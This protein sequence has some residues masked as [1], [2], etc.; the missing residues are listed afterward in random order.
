MTEYGFENV[1]INEVLTNILKDQAKTLIFQ[2]MVKLINIYMEYKFQAI[3][4]DRG[5]K[6][7]AQTGD[8]KMDIKE[9][10]LKKTLY[11]KIFVGY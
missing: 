7:G 8:I 1:C 6:I 9:E 10:L 3:M 5:A 11:F 2:T 4:W